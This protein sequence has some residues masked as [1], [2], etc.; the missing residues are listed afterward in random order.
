[1]SAFKDEFIVPDNY[2]M[3]DIKHRVK[4]WNASPL[5]EDYI[6]EV[7]SD[8]HI[9]LTKAKHDLKLC[10]LP[11]IAP[12]VGL[13]ILFLFVAAGP[14]G[15]LFGMAVYLVLI[16]AIEIWAVYKFCLNPKKAVYEIMFSNEMPIRIH[17]YASG[18]IAASAHE[19]RALRDSLYGSS[20]DQ[21]MGPNF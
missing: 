15:F 19:Y 21:G 20:G 5:G 10:F 9:I 3:E 4:S 7:K 1:V 12:F 17:V 14:S 2:S 8:R 16:L 13:P 18:E 6:M 11:C